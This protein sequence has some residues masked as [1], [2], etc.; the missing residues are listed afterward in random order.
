MSV[1]RR[2]CVGE[3]FLLVG[4]VRGEDPAD[5]VV[6][7]TRSLAASIRRVFCIIAFGETV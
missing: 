4:E 5:A 1:R 3:L 7:G 6:I 2:L